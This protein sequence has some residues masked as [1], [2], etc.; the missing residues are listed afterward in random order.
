MTSIHNTTRLLRG[1]QARDHLGALACTPHSV[2]VAGSSFIEPVATGRR[3]P[4][5][6]RGADSI[7]DLDELGLPQH[8]FEPAQRHHHACFLRRHPGGPAPGDPRSGRIALFYA[9][10]SVALWIAVALVV[11]VFGRT[12]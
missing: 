7:A 4:H 12:I 2:G 11:A 1:I 5:L 3:R 8:E 6:V 10:L 9:A